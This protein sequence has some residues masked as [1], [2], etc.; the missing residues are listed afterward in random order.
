MKLEVYRR[1]DGKWA[2]R[3]RAANGQVVATDGGQ[4]YDHAA[5][6]QNMAMRVTDGSVVTS[7]E[8]FGA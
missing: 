2:W 1:E 4:G 8:V 7:M 6:A 5:D 3:V